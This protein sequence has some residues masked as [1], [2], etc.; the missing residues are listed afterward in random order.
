[1]I[2]LAAGLT[3]AG[4]FVAV[5]LGYELQIYGDGSLF[6]YALAVRDAWAFHW[7]NIPTRAFVYLYALAPAEAYVW[8]T[9]DARGA[10]ALYGL[11][12]FVAPLLGLAAT[13]ATDRSRGRIV[14]AF[15]CFSTAAF[16]PFVF[17]F[18]TEMWIGHAVFWPTLAFGLYGRGAVATALLCAGMFALAFTHE[19]ALLLA[20][21]IVATLALRGFRDRA[22]LRAAGIFAA[23]ALIWLAV[24]VG[25]PPDPY[26]SRF[27][28]NAAQNFFE[29]SVFLEAEAFMLWL[30][31][32]VGYG[33]A[34]LL[35]RRLAPASAAIY[36][37]SIVA[38]G[39][40][41]YWLW[42][43][44]SLHAVDRY[45][46]RTLLVLTTPVVGA[47]AAAFALKAE[48]RLALKVPLLPHALAAGTNRPL[49]VAIS[50]ALL[51]TLLVHAVETAK[52]VTVWTNYKDAVRTLA[53]GSTSD[54][55]L[56]D[57]RFVSA[58]RIRADLN[59]VSWFSTTH[60]LSVLLAPKFAPA[61]L[62]VDPDAAFVWLSCETATANR[63][64]DRALPS[65]SRELVR[66][67]E[68]L[69]RRP[70]I[71]APAR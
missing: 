51:L 44:R 17:G 36:A 8:L 47:L 12:F 52:F 67:H 11:L 64:A 2:A 31:A 57:P 5:G 42:F 27:F 55:A 22:F 60:F 46:L 18:T 59:E 15:A 20:A 29:L 39:L 62:V 38:L 9:G 10:I 21:A 3:C 69:H 1:M 24:R 13:Y 37:A 41:A 32:M 56:G 50:G 28:R 70:P 7:H 34:L 14:F 65:E 4:L 33:A 6:S 43:D 19:G 71:H 61:R 48:G 30:A 58:H 26:F 45:Y 54:P 63:A 16:C 23:A 25:V 49:V 68:C 66:V 35:L 40:A 53:M